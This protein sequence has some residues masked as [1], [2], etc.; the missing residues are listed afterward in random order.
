M[1]TIKEVIIKTISIGSMDDSRLTISVEASSI[2]GST[3]FDL[4]A[5]ASGANLPRSLYPS[6]RVSNSSIG[7]IGMY[8]SVAD[9]LRILLS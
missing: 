1:V 3:N 4:H 2:F 7:R 5:D 9:K 8:I 6:L